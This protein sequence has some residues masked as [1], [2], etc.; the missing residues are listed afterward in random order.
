MNL[1]VAGIH[2]RLTTVWPESSMRV[3]LVGSYDLP[4]DPPPPATTDVF[5][6]GGE[7]GE[8]ISGESGEEIRRE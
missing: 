5:V 3:R 7:A 4:Y 6:I 8:I 2:G 1:I